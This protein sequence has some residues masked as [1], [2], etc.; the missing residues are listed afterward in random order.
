M[1]T[2]EITLPD[3]LAQEAQQAGLLAPEL[4]ENWLREQLKARRIQELFEA[5]DRM[6]AVDDPSPMTPEEVADEIQAVRA[7]RRARTVPCG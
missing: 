1:T 7:E 3:Q 5:V 4:L 6:R 2:L